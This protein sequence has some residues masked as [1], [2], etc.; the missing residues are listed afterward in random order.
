M[1]LTSGLYFSAK[2]AERPKSK[3]GMNRPIRG[4]DAYRGRKYSLSEDTTTEAARRLRA[5]NEARARGDVVRLD[6]NVW[7][8]NGKR[9]V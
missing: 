6:G 7:T 1:S 4:V 8:I 3:R 9:A 5:V 2:P